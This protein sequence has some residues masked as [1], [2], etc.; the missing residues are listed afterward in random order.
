[1]VFTILSAI[2][3]LTNIRFSH[4]E[5]TD[6]VYIEDEYPLEVVCTLLGLDQELLTMALIS[7]F[8]TTK[9][10]SQSLRRRPRRSNRGRFILGE[11]VISLKNFAQANDCRD[12]L[13]KALY[14]RLFS[15][16]VKHINT[17]LQP[18]RR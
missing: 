4:D 2:L 1:M 15:W 18:N 10:E 12:A 5:E 16:I 6:G 9:G 17:L 8:S 3:H 11:R 13:A 14:E 7:T